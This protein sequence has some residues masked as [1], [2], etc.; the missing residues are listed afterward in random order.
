MAFLLAACQPSVVKET[1]IVEKEVTREVE[2]KEEAPPAPKEPIT[3]RVATRAGSVAGTPGIFGRPAAVLMLENPHVTI[4][5]GVYGL[6]EPNRVAMVG[7]TGVLS[8]TAEA[9][10]F[11][12]DIVLA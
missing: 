12:P 3:L 2:R 10:C 4:V 6:R 5:A 1:V 7:R 8:R 9:D 11:S